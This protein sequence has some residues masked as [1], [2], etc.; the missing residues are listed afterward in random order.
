VAP[1]GPPWSCTSSPPEETALHRCQ[2]CRFDTELDDVVLRFASGTCL[3]LRC[4]GRATDAARPMPKALRRD[5][6]A[7]LAAAV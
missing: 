3:C 2:I 1:P 4:Y 5:L 7:A 6:I